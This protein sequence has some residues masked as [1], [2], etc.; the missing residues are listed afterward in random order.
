MR[1]KFLLLKLPSLWY[2]VIEPKLTKIPTLD[3]TFSLDCDSVW[4]SSTWPNK[5]QGLAYNICS[6]FWQNYGTSLCVP[7]GTCFVLLVYSYFGKAINWEMIVFERKARKESQWVGFTYTRPFLWKVRLR[8]GSMN[9]DIKP[10]NA[11]N[12]YLSEVVRY[13]GGWTRYPRCAG[14]IPGHSNPRDCFPDVSGHSLAGCLS[15][16]YLLPQPV[17]LFHW[18]KF[19]GLRAATWR[20]VGH[21][22]L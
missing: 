14:L 3:H 17:K 2:C 10:L 19:C 12:R 4:C 13:N 1:N 8:R 16:L 22:D 18:K 5:G 11:E 15:L 6:I 21:A 9:K 7:N 20:I